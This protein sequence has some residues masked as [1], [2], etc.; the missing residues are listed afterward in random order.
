MQLCLSFCTNINSIKAFKIL[1]NTKKLK[2]KE[3]KHFKK[4]K[5]IFVQVQK[6]RQ[7][8]GKKIES[9]QRSSRSNIILLSPIHPGLSSWEIKYHLVNNNNQ[10]NAS[11][12]VCNKNKQTK[13]QKKK[14]KN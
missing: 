14:K 9:A 12:T 3:T 10:L 8:E 11:T 7:G 6:R 5:F 4:P 13:F 2:I 1:Q